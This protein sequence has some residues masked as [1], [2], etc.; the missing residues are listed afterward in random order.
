MYLTIDYVLKSAKYKDDVS[1]C[2]KVNVA[3]NRIFSNSKSYLPVFWLLNQG[4]LYTDL[5]LADEDASQRLAN[6]HT[7]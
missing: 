1:F 5:S 3:K 4:A 6:R 2:A 7:S